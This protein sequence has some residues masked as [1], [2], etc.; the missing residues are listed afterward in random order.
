M[1]QFSPGSARFQPD[2]SF[3]QSLDRADPLRDFRAQFHI[4][5]RPD[6]T[7]TIYFCGNSLGLQPKKAKQYVDLVLDDWKNLGV[8]GHFYAQHPWT[9]YHELLTEKMA[10]A[11]GA[12]PSETVV[13]NTLTVN[14]HLLMASFYRPTPQRYK[15]L[16]DWNPFPS[17]RYAVASQVRFHGFDPEQALLEPQPRSGSALV[18]TAD[19]LELI[20]QE[21]DSIALIMIGG[22]NYYS[23]QLYD[24]KAIAEAGRRKGC[25]VGFDLA[26]AAGNVPL[27]LHDSGCDFAVWC[28]YKYMNSGPGALGGCFVHERH[29]HAVLPRF[30]GWWGH[31]KSTRFKMGPDFVPIGGAESWLLSNPPVLALAPVRASLEVFEEAGMERL[32]AKSRLLTGY[33]E[34]LID[35]IPTDKIRIITPREPAQRGCQLSVRVSGAD[36]SLFHALMAR[37]VITDWR[38]PD[39][40]R[41]APTPLYNRFEEV[42]RFVD[43]LKDLV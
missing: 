10:R 23:G 19:L 7:K 3:A 1:E 16:T 18:D 32:S 43:I 13:M 29:A 30:E 42:W 21:G 24:L 41:A 39:V 37:G 14:L 9:T 5:L 40:V 33:L 20:E 36:K 31:E 35:R 4:P 6:G 17:D 22:I 8:E 34:Y 25:A 12:L 26:H 38:E 28:T 11:V 27:Q 15:I 2:L